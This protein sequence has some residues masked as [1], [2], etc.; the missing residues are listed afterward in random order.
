V[1]SVTR[2]VPTV[3]ITRGCNLCEMINHLA[4]CK[5][6]DQ[7]ASVVNNGKCFR[8]VGAHDRCGPVEVLTR[9]QSGVR[10][11]SSGQWL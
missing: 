6:S 7:C 8:L 4:V 5:D 11:G 10:S 2:A 3:S 1:R 9:Q